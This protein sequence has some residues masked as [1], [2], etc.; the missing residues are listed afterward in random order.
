MNDEAFQSYHKRVGS[1]VVLIAWLVK[2]SGG[3]SFSSTGKSNQN[4]RRTPVPVREQQGS[5]VEGVDDRVSLAHTHSPFIGSGDS[6]GDMAHFRLVCA[7]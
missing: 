4:G 3:E 1:L 5:R 7:Q 6:A 2:L